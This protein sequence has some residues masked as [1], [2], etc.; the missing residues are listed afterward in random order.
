MKNGKT[1]TEKYGKILRPLL[2]T[3]IQAITFSGG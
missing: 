2:G 3:N 1:V